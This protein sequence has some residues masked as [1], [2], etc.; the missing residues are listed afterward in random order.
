MFLSTLN[1]KQQEAFLNLAHSVV[2]SDGD[3]TTAEDVMLLD[4]RREMDL[5]PTKEAHY[6]DVDGADKIFDTRRSRIVAL[7][8]LIRLGYADG[9]FEVEEKSF[10]KR[11]CNLFDISN[12]EL[13]LLENWVRRLISLEREAQ[14][15]M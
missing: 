15:L 11:L 5:A 7:I 6:V 3:L 2:V 9:A 1:Q 8:S 4:M 10:I 13:S 12:E 14:Q